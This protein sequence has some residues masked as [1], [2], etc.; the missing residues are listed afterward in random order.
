MARGF[1]IFIDCT[2]FVSDQGLKCESCLETL[3]I[4]GR[5]HLSKGENPEEESSVVPLWSEFDSSDHH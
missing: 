4:R 1:L 3:S 5:M 2:H